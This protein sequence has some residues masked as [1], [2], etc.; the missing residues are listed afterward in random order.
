MRLVMSLK[1]SVNRVMVLRFFAAACMV[2]WSS[3][4]GVLAETQDGIDFRV[5]DDV[6]ALV[7]K[8]LANELL[9]RDIELQYQSH[10]QCLRPLG[11]DGE[12]SEHITTA[13]EISQGEQYW[14]DYDMRGKKQ[15]G[16]GLVDES[17]LVVC[18]G[19]TTRNWAQH[20]IGNVHLDRWETPLL[21]SP[22]RFIT[23]IPDVSVSRYLAEGMAIGRVKPSALGFV[24]TERLSLADEQQ[25]LGHRC[26]VVERRLILA[27]RTTGRQG[28]HHI[29]RLWICPE[30]NYLPLKMTSH[31]LSGDKETIRQ[32]MRIDALQEFEP[33]VSFPKHATRNFY[34]S[35]GALCGTQTWQ[36]DSVKLR[37]NYPPT[38]FDPK[39]VSFSK[40]ALVYY[41]KNG[42]II[43]QNSGEM[44]DQRIAAVLAD[45]SSSPAA[46]RPSVSPT[47]MPAGGMGR[48]RR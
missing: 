30:M 20:R 47:T 14:L 44:E 10:Y 42:E 41:I 21:F 26:V 39:S 3:T 40:D 37:P 24:A 11:L 34:E 25:Y 33:G 5:T 36:F 32:E 22:H 13:H 18:D 27:P 45:M 29:G 31:D 35:D 46:S 23:F 28:S 15:G 16:D 2:F 12:V 6:K 4:N 19:T 9:Y 8:L 38:R 48:G 1:T 43:A 17:S 7:P